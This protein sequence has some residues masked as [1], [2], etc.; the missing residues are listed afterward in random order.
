MIWMKTMHQRNFK[1][2][3]GAKRS[4][5]RWKIPRDD[6]KPVGGTETLVLGELISPK[7]SKIPRRNQG[8]ANGG[9]GVTLTVVLEWE[10]EKWE[11][12]WRC[13]FC[14]GGLNPQKPDS[15]VFKTGQSD[16][17]WTTKNSRWGARNLDMSGSGVGHVQPIS[18]EPGLRTGYV[19]SGT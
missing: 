8:I 9:F 16:L 17:S 18:L 10:R 11:K 3:H 13:K 2:I 6:K 19:R 14:P 1:S 4:R 7:N 15:L 5:I 12:L